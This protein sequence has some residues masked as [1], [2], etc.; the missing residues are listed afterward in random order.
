M[1]VR[2]PSKR[3]RSHK[4]SRQTKENSR[5]KQH[6]SGYCSSLRGQYNLFHYA[7][8]MNSEQLAE[9]S[10]QAKKL[11]KA[12]RAA[13]PKAFAVLAVINQLARL[14]C[15]KFNFQV[16]VQD[17]KTLAQT[18]NLDINQY[19]KRFNTLP[20][21]ARIYLNKQDVLREALKAGTAWA[22]A[23]DRKNEARTSD[24]YMKADLA[25]RRAMT[26][27]TGRLLTGFASGLRDADSETAFTQHFISSQ[28]KNPTHYQTLQKN[29]EKNM[30]A[31]I[32]KTIATVINDRVPFPFRPGV[33]LY[34]NRKIATRVNAKSVTNFLNLVANIPSTGDAPITDLNTLKK[35]P[36]WTNQVVDLVSETQGWSSNLK[37][38]VKKIMKHHRGMKELAKSLETTH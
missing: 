37:Q 26:D 29:T 9:F 38:N 14:F 15:S 36:V 20:Q 34:A 16:S 5:V 2:L 28:L 11:P 6:G 33:R 32:Q 13:L 3:R 19:D 18:L 27:A 24:E 35:H 21:E 10:Q 23:R 25:Q 1:P 17:A 31:A 7:S 4:K 8:K 12:L 22:Q 30:D